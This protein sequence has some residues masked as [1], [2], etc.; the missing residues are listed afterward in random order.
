[1]PNTMSNW[2][3]ELSTLFR[4]L[5]SGVANTLIGFAVI[6]L[7]VSLGV[8]PFASNALGYASGLSVG[9]FLAR[10]VVFQSDGNLFAQG[11]RYILAFI[12]SYFANLATLF[13]CVNQFEAEKYTSQ[14]LASGTYIALMYPLSRWIVFR[15]RA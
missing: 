15:R 11:W 5:G 14:I 2:K 7:L 8:G 3:S 4:Y 10:Y 12:L 9:F 1:M 13:I 6:F